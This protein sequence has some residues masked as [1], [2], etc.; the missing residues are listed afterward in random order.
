M[1]KWLLLGRGSCAK[2]AACHV[3]DHVPIVLRNGLYFSG[4]RILQALRGLSEVSHLRF[5][6][7]S[8]WQT[9]GPSFVG[10]ESHADN[11]P[12]HRRDLLKPAPR[13]FASITFL[14]AIA[15]IELVLAPNGTMQA[16]S[17]RRRTTTAWFRIG[18]WVNFCV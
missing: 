1:H 4:R 3:A 17:A 2:V 15:A 5:L 11:C 12:M 9:L 8:S 13:T 16:F 7:T 10:S 6:P 14:H 18:S